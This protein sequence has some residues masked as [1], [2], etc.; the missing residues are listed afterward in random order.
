[1]NNMK[2]IVFDISRYCLD[3]GPGIRTTVYLKGC[4]LQ[5]IWCHNPESNSQKIEIGYD[6]KRC[7]GCQLCSRICPRGCHEFQNGVHMFSRKKCIACGKCVEVC[8]IEAL[9]QIGKMMTVDEVLKIVE[10]DQAFYKSSNGGL[11]L[12]GGE[13]MFQFD[14]SKSLLKAAQ[15]KGISTCVETSGFINKEKLLEIISYIDLFLYD[16]KQMNSYIHK[17]VTGVH[18]EIIINNLY[19]IDRLGKSIILRLPIIPGINDN[20]EHFQKL[21]KLADDLKNVLY[22]EVLPYH[23]LGLSKAQLLDKTMKYD[24]TEIPESF[25]V[26]DWVRQIQFYTNKKVI[27]SKV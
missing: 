3:D 23:P 4:P 7:I 12:S 11:T 9:T 22:L 6:I 1:M 20:K 16:C 15:E 2:G 27:K 5:C 21:G 17:E 25:Q 8:E 19:E 14:F 26:D 13:M 24:S 18:N 10:R